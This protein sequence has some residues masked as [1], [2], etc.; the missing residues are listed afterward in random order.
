MAS[1]GPYS[2]SGIQTRL[3]IH[4]MHLKKVGYA[5]I[6][7]KLYVLLDSVHLLSASLILKISETKISVF[8]QCPFLY[9]FIT[10]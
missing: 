1:Y 2:D 6:F 10:S 8:N 3:E 4:Q 9:F 7:I 5:K